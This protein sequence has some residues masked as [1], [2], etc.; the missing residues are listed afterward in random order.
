MEDNRPDILSYDEVE[1][2]IKGLEPSDIW[3]LGLRNY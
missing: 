2:Y 1:A 3:E